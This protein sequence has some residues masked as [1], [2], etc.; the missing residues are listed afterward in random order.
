MR[1]NVLL[2]IP[3]LHQGGSERQGI[4]LAQLLS[5]TGRYRVTLAC[6][7]R[8]GA[9]L[10]EAESLALGEIPEFRLNSFYDRNMLTQLR[11]SVKLLK[12]QSIDVVQTF[13]FYTNVFGLT[14]A[15]L[16][17]VPLRVGARR[18]TAG[19]RTAAQKWIERRAFLLSHVI[20][21][22]SEAVQ[23]E[24]IGD[25]VRASKIVTVYNAVSINP[26]IPKIGS[27]RAGLL[28]SLALPTD[29]GHRFITIVANLRSPYKDHPTFLR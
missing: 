18:E 4:R 21:A 28:R 26:Q 10:P 8:T 15:A 2:M 20:V 1:L 16:A 3:S 29:P 12:T 23:Q 5:G 17:R 6:L 13:D 25:G 24:L 14:A 11:R 9:L 7:D 19:H 27:D 22:N